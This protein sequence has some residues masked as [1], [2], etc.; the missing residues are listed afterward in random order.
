[1]STKP[2]VSAASDASAYNRARLFAL[3]VIALATGGMV[4]SI[5][6]EILLT[7]EQ[8]FFV[9]VD[10]LHSAELIGAAVGAAFLGLAI[11]NFVGG[12]LCDWVGMNRLLGIASLLHIAGAAV[13]IFTGPISSAF[14]VFWVMWAG[15]MSV[16]LAHGLIEAVIN[17]LTAT[18]YPEDK[19]H[20][21]NVLHAWWP[22]GLI[23]G[24][25]VA[26]GL[27]RLGVGWQIKQA[28][29]ILP[30]IVY[31]V[32]AL[33]TKFPPTERVAAG[34]RDK[35]MFKEALKPLFILWWL[36]MW[37]TAT[38][39]LTTGQWVDSLLTRTV[40]F[41]GILL[42]VYVSGLMFV[43]RH[44]A[45]GLA[46][47]LSPVGLM[48]FSSVLAAAGLLFLSAA[49]SPVTGL[50]AATVWG[51][52]I[53]YMWPTMLAVAS[54]RFPKGGAFLL[55]LIGTAGNLSIFFTMP[56]MGAIF[57]H[58][59]V[60]AAKAMGTSFEV[61]SKRPAGDPELNQVLSIASSYSFKYVAILPAVLIVV[62][63]LLWLRD[64]AMGGYKAVRLTA[65]HAEQ[66][67]E[68]VEA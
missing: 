12:P 51:I 49:N 46:H 10:K 35:D 44:F 68:K 23:I 54:E 17:P 9:P 24:G 5:R 65:E 50:L 13:I 40:G 67:T 59:K 43:M 32:M 14:S 26:Y 41:K 61:L 22:G 7:L 6:G 3:S 42:L 34:I 27:G 55:G 36:C 48:W 20:K 38:T 63:G 60:E 1:M 52:G 45:G 21:L 39:E 53:C 8:T 33:T 64:K 58:Y 30:A 15:M 4:F 11:A 25:L 28:V 19:T 2:T 18:L 62:F 47:R 16:G 31:G 37:L 56:R 66:P 29:I 57:D